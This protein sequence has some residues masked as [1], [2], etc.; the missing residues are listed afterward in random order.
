M[1]TVLNCQA[2][3]PGRLRTDSRAGGKSRQFA[4]F[5]LRGEPALK[6]A[7]IISHQLK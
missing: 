2:T 7:A 3:F 6:I 5:K 1:P 4:V